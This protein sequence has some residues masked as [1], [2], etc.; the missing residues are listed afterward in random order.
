MQASIPKGTRDFGPSTLLKRRYIQNTIQQVFELFGFEPLET[1]AMENIE[2]LTGKY[3]DEGDKL[4]FRILNNGAI[5][6]GALKTENNNQLIQAVSEKALRYDLTIPFA[7]FVAM[8]RGTLTFPFKRYQIQPVWRADRP[9][10][11]RFREFYQCDADVIG[12][13][14][15]LAE[16]ELIRIYAEVF[17][18]LTIPVQIAINNRKILAGLA[19]W[20]EVSDRLTEMTILLDKLDKVAW[21]KLKEEFVKIQFSEDQ[22]SKIEKFLSIT[23]SNEAV[24]DELALLFDNCAIGKLG[25]EELRTI[26]EKFEAIYGSNASIKIDFK[27]ARGLNY[28]TGLIVEVKATT[29]VMGS[30]GG[31]GRYDDLTGIFGFPGMSGVGISFGL[32]RIYEVLEELNLFP[33]QSSNNTRVL[34]LNF[35][36][37][38]E[39][40][41]MKLM[42]TLRKESISSEIYPSAE[43]IKKQLEYANKKQI[44]FVVLLGEAELTKEQ[45]ILKNMQSGEQTPCNFDNLLKQ[46][47]LQLSNLNK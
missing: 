40:A 39:L 23:G 4:L 36:P 1:P 31:G 3:G 25:M 2:T 29:V 20:A 14:S 8:N 32:D 12:T 13:T 16:V 38:E 11:G 26:L 46:I 30:I 41:A 47:N 21:E 44:P 45:V 35:G 37:S 28:Y 7:R 24:L 5:Y 22:I 43:K 34:F 18:K 27:L 42:S 15:L 9:Q 10:K 19:E 17:E 6:E 33:N